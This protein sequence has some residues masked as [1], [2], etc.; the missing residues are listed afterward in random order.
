MRHQAVG[1][2]KPGSAHVEG[3]IEESTSE[4]TEDAR[5]WRRG[6]RIERQHELV[7]AE[8]SGRCAGSWGATDNSGPAWASTV[9][10]FR[11][12]AVYGFDR[13]LRET[14]APLDDTS[15]PIARGS[16]FSCGNRGRDRFTHE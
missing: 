16:Q 6:P 12:H 4:W 8:A 5:W 2:I 15:V 14:R 3:E 1:E 13:G 11:L 9:P 10:R 7:V